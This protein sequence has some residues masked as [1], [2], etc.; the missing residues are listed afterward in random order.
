MAPTVAPDTTK[1][2]PLE[3]P[4]DRSRGKRKDGRAREGERR[5]DDVDQ[6]E[7][8]GEQDG[9][10]GTQ[11]RKPPAVRLQAFQR[12]VLPQVEEVERRDD[13]GERDEDQDLPGFHPETFPSG[14]H[15]L[16]F[17]SKRKRRIFFVRS[18]NSFSE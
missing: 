2:G 3:N 7:D 4:E 10:R 1:Q 16:P 13:R 18:P 11:I 5:L 17:R 8:G 15:A 9:V 6:D 14:V 12:Q